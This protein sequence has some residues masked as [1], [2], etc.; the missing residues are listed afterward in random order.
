[1]LHAFFFVYTE[2]GLII[3]QKLF[4]QR[5]IKCFVLPL[6]HSGHPVVFEQLVA[7]SLYTGLKGSSVG[8]F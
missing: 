6:W 7:A 5:F 4:Y 3:S 1:M 8:L 2:I